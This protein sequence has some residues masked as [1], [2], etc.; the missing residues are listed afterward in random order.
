LIAFERLIEA[1]KEKSYNNG[2]IEFWQIEGLIVVGRNEAT[3]L[4]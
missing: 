1:G 4:W 2:N 3:T